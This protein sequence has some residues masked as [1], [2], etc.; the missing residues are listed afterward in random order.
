MRRVR[1]SEKEI[2]ESL[3]IADYLAIDRTIMANERTLL[4]YV[5]SAVGLLIAGL[6][7]IR[8]FHQTHFDIYQIAGFAALLVALSIM[9]YGI[10]DF[11]HMH[12]IYT[13]LQEQEKK[14]DRNIHQRD[15]SF[16]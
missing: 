3:S 9:I 7:L 14:T 4:A 10:R 15:G 11:I 2:N 16:P 5:R 6:A 13:S 1:Y 12:K 8:F